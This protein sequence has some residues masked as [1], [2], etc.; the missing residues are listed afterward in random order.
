MD[1]FIRDDFRGTHGTPNVNTTPQLSLDSTGK[2]QIMGEST[3]N[4]ITT[5]FSPYGCFS[6]DFFNLPTCLVS[7]GSPASFSKNVSYLQSP[8]RNVPT[9]PYFRGNHLT[10]GVNLP[11]QL[12]RDNTRENQTQGESAVNTSTTLVRPLNFPAV[13][14]LPLSR[15]AGSVA[16]STHLTFLGSSAYR[17]VNEAC[18]SNIPLPKHLQSSTVKTKSH[19]VSVQGKES[20]RKRRSS[21][22]CSN[23]DP[24]QPRVAFV[25]LAVKQGSPTDDELQELGNEIAG[26]WMRL[27]RCLGVKEPNLQ[28]IEQN[29]RQLPEK[30]YYMLMHWKQENGSTATYQI[31]N[32][33]LQHELVQRKDLA[34]KICHKNDG[35]AVK[36]F[37]HLTSVRVSDSELDLSKT[38]PD[39]QRETDVTPSGVTYKQ[40]RFINLVH[41]SFD[42]VESKTELLRHCLN[43]TEGIIFLWPSGRSISDLVPDRKILNEVSIRGVV[44]CDRW[45]CDK[46]TVLCESLELLNCLHIPLKATE[47]LAA[48][49]AEELLKKFESVKCAGLCGFGCILHFHSGQSLFYFSELELWCDDHAKLFTEN[50]APSHSAS[51]CPK[52]SSLKFFRFLDFASG[53]KEPTMRSFSTIIRDCKSFESFTMA[54]LNESALECLEQIPNPLK[55]RLR[56][57]GHV[58]C[59]SLTS[60]EVLKLASLL[61]RFNNL[62]K[63]DLSFYDW[64]AETEN[65]LVCSITHKTLQELRLWNL[66]M[67][68][69]IAAALGR[70]LPEMLSLKKL[71]LK[72]RKGSTVQV[73][74]MKALFGGFNKT[75]PPLEEFMFSFCG[76][77]GFFV[78]LTECSRYSPSLREVDLSG[79]NL[80]QRDLHGLVCILKSIPN[81]GIPCLKGNP[82]GD[83]NMGGIYRETS[84]ASG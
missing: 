70:S 49:S 61:P 4:S 79:S 12:M 50:F 72:G 33:A 43:C 83:K 48:V 28:D 80:N 82:L 37:E 57:G 9:R 71:W 8:A 59:N 69:A 44:F 16:Q 47:N 3:V 5:V 7:S 55:C 81:L 63:F 76:F 35:G 26:K 32:A 74:D 73:E 6:Q 18:Y 11:P 30:G 66:R 67:T 1:V 15:A 68:P 34:E 56:L 54:D 77:R 27:G 36:V 23:Q 10:P 60:S 38:I 24:K 13:P 2:S 46:M 75:F 25:D 52:S 22:G 53:I 19:S 58:F 41:D 39:E 51:L 42:E 20:R 21:P 62:I 40:R 78:Q 64:C 45:G 31:L 65:K 14:A 17:S 84:T 29:H